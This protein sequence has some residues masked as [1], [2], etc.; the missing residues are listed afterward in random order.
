MGKIKKIKITE[1]EEK[2]L[3]SIIKKDER[4]RVRNRA[5]AILYKCKA[6]AVED[7]A[8]LLNVR[9]QTVYL[10]LRKYEQ[11]GLESLYDKEGKGRIGI[12]T[13]EYEEEIKALVLNQPSLT[14]ANARIREKLKLY[15]HNETLRKY[16]KKNKIQLYTGSK[17]T[18]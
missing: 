6:Y 14:V 1:Q 8:K 16:L 13:S 10:W 7:I 4:Y 9:P 18:T 12:L 2:E 5:N 11:E 17:E 3:E 15:V